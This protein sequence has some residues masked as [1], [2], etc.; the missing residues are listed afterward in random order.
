MAREPTTRD[1]WER[2]RAALPER[3]DA[4]TVTD[5]VHRLK[6]EIECGPKR[7]MGLNEITEHELITRRGF[8][9]YPYD[10]APPSRELG[11][12]AG[13]EVLQMARWFRKRRK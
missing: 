2:L 7:W 1:D 4:W 3:Y 8:L 13:E 11:D 12:V 10:S 5:D 9:T 6:F